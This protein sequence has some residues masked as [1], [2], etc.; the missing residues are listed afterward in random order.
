MNAKAKYAATPRKPNAAKIMKMFDKGSAQGSCV[1]APR[2]GYHSGLMHTAASI[3]LTCLHVVMALAVSVF[4]LLFG[5]NRVRRGVAVRVLVDGIGSGYFVSAAYRQ[6]QRVDVPVARFMQK[7][8]CIDGQMAFCGGLNIGAENFTREA[9]ARPVYDTH[10]VVAADLYSVA[11]HV[12][13]AGWTWYTGAAGWLYRSGLESI[14]GFLLQGDHLSLN[15]CIPTGWP[16]VDGEVLPVGGSRVLLRD[17]GVTHQVRV[18]LGR[19]LSD[20]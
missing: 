5:I 6:L 19:G 15:P 1:A 10:F 9:P 3:T 8:L 11:P 2:S 17:D 4:Y 13:R 12:G 14:L 20:E 7:V 18:T 16:G